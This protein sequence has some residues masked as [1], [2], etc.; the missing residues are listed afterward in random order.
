MWAT[1]SQTV[2]VQGSECYTKCFIH[3]CSGG[4][5]VRI[6]LD[7]MSEELMWQS[8]S[9]L[10][11]RAPYIYIYIYINV[12]YI[13]MYLFYVKSKLTGLKKKI[14]IYIYIYLFWTT[15]RKTCSRLNFLYFTNS[16]TQ[17]A[18]DPDIFRVLSLSNA[19]HPQ[20]FVNVVAWIPNHSPKNDQDVIHIQRLHNLIGCTL[21]GGHGFPDLQRKQNTEHDLSLSS[22]WHYWAKDTKTNQFNS[23]YLEKKSKCFP[24]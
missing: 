21:I 12:I 18:T 7:T 5:L 1:W 13:F 15:T 11:H 8:H 20:E 19:H 2:T 24:K 10:K 23:C 4:A 14:Y 16:A 22:R 3:L 9:T 6:H 17:I